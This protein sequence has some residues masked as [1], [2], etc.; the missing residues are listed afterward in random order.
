MDYDGRDTVNI[1]CLV[2]LLLVLILILSD[3]TALKVLCGVV[4]MC[5]TLNVIVNWIAKNFPGR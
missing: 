1:P 5:L 3:I 2:W 4:L